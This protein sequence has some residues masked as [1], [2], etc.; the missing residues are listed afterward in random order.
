VSKHTSGPWTADAYGVIT[1]GVDGCTSVAETPQCKWER[2]DGGLGSFIA[3][4]HRAELVAECK[5]NARLIAA[6]PDMYDLVAG[7][8]VMDITAIRTAGRMA[9]VLRG[10][11]LDASYIV[12][13]AQGETE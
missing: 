3:D 7:L 9:E 13:K 11:K 10:I 5:A 8:A 1:G 12:R 4:N 2:N 6:A